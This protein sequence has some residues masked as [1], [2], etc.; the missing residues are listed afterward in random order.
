M[1]VWT[2]HLA[3]ASLAAVTAAT[4]VTG[5]G[6]GGGSASG[7]GVLKLWTHNA[8]NAAEYAAVEKLVNGF[9]GSQ[10]TY[11]VEI[12]AFPQGSYNDAVVASST[13]KKLPCIL[14]VD[15]PNV[16]NWAW[17]GYLAPLELSG[18]EVPLDDQLPSTVGRY[19]D[20]VY[21][22]GFY[23]VA[24]TTFARKSVLEKNSIRIPTPE[25]PWTRAEF[26]AALAKLK[27]TGGF[28]HPLEM[29][30]G[31]SGEWWP[32]AYSPQLQ[33]FGADLVDRSS[34]FRNAFDS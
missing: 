12:E 15:G 13:S 6:T 23:D 10:P 31:G 24:L 9:N 20:K 14:D 2:R 7:N 21:S 17:G 1:N 4:A 22:F 34:Y 30:T 26:S 32:Y 11:K 16:A 8:G 3:A 5:C 18:G 25:Q 28:E 33:S 27:A 29:G 19:Q